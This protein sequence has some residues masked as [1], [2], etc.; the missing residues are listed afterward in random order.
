VYELRPKVKVR[1]LRYGES[2]SGKTEMIRTW[3][4]DIEAGEWMAIFDFDGGLNTIRNPISG[5]LPE[6]MFGL[7][8]RDTKRRVTADPKLMQ[9]E[10]SGFKNAR[11]ALEELTMGEGVLEFIPEEAQKEREWN[12]MPT[13]VV[14]DTLTGLHDV[15]MNQALTLD[16]KTGLAGAPAMHHWGAQMRLVEEFVKMCEAH[17]WHLDVTAHVQAWKDDLL[18]STR[19]TLL[20]TGQ[21]SPGLIPGWFDEVYYHTISSTDV[22]VNYVIKPKNDGFFVAKSRL[23]LLV[24]SINVTLP[25]DVLLFKEPAGSG[26]YG[27]GNIFHIL[28][29]QYGTD[30]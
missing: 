21:K 18:G 2:G 25:D 4:L 17:E 9:R 16:P 29:E 28:A 1:A 11:N 6:G 23:G 27:W 10:A 5:E 22:G 7:T 8:F 20:V 26:E 14:L 3:P 13:V 19:G 15:A 12:Q 30:T 24:P